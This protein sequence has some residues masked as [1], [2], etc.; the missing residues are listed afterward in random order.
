MYDLGATEMSETTDLVES[1]EVNLLFK[2]WVM[3][4]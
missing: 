2:S 1:I 3:I 4:L